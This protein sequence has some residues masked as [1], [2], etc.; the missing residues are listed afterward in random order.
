MKKITVITSK[1]S[2]FSWASLLELWEYREMLVLWI[3]RDIRV[4]YIQSTLGFGW[5][6]FPMLSQ[7]LIY[8][9]VFGKLVRIDSDGAPY[10]LFALAGVVPWIFFSQAINSVASSVYGAGSFLQKIY[11]PRLILPIAAL[12]DKF[13]D[14]LI[15]F[16]LLLIVLLVSGVSFGPNVLIVPFLIL[17]IMM[18]AL[19]FGML[20]AAMAVH[21]RD[22]LHLMG[23][24]T[25]AMMYGSPVVY[26]ISLVPSA[27]HAVYSLNPMVGVIE[28]FRSAFL[29][30]RPMPWDLILTATMVSS[31]GLIAGILYFKSAES[32]FADVG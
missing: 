8:T 11:F 14:F 22:I 19:G 12:F 20:A 30:T 13:F 27:Y 1:T 25:M 9:I 23:Y 2:Q 6:L 3:W 31:C 16:T 28:G 24:I 10:A 21:F 26:P 29:A 17:I 18:T 5:A 32:K 7:V 4:R 15:S